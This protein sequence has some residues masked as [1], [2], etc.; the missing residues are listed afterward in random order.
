[1]KGKVSTSWPFQQ[2]IPIHRKSKPEHDTSEH[3][4]QIEFYKS[5]KIVILRETPFKIRFPNFRNLSYLKKRME[6][7]TD[8]WLWEFL[9]LGGFEGLV[10]INQITRLYFNFN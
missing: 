4:N 7:A 2:N 10:S 8:R 9:S 1:M 6:N 5:L 3:I